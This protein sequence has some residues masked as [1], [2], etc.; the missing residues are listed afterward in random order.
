MVLL[1]T[2]ERGAE[3]ISA[4]FV[5]VIISVSCALF[6]VV[7]LKSGVIGILWAQ[8]ISAVCGLIF[9]IWLIRDWIKLALIRFPAQDIRDS[10][11]YTFP[12]IPHILS[13]YVYMYSDRLI[14]QRYVPLADIGIYSIADT[15]AYILAVIVSSTTTAYGPRFLKLAEENK[16]KSQN[17][18]KEFINIWWAG[19]MIVFMGYLLFSDTLV[20]VMT[21]PSFYPAIPLIPILASAYIF[22]GLYCFATNGIFFSEKTRVV[23]IITITAA[24]V[25]IALNLIFI[26]KYGIFAAAWSTVISYFVTFVLAY[27]FSKKYFPVIYPWRN[28][29]NIAFLLLLGCIAAVI[30]SRAWPSKPALVQF[31]FNIMVFFSFAVIIMLSLYRKIYAFAATKPL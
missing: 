1:Q 10:M 6:F 7:F 14:L 25:N 23:P 19:I 4:V 5:Q 21:R 24:L 8:F 9:I 27:C 13:I 12:M 17:E 3:F 2:L 18:T 30:F 26:P 31:S 29:I 28:M 20:R 22:R 11:R 16:L 15:F